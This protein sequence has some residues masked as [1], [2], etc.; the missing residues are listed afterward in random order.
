MK[1]VTPAP[2]IA[3]EKATSSL[4]T[5]GGLRKL[6]GT[7]CKLG[8]GSREPAS[9]QVLSV[10]TVGSS[11]EVESCI[12]DDT[13]DYCPSVRGGD[14]KLAECTRELKASLR[15]QPDNSSRHD[16]KKVSALYDDAKSLEEAHV[17]SSS[18]PEPTF[19]IAL[20]PSRLHG[21]P[22]KS[23]KK[24]R[25]AMQVY[26]NVYLQEPSLNV[27]ETDVAIR[28]KSPYSTPPSNIS[29]TCD[30]KETNREPS[31]LYVEPNEIRPLQMA[32]FKK[33][34]EDE[35]KKLTMPKWQKDLLPQTDKKQKP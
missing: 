19:K 2:E 11:E 5:T 3:A 29:L 27:I 32:I 15:C 4:A 13:G 17:A 28:D 35:K 21:T 12:Y 6:F 23:G 16:F 22:K 20:M 10:V 1:S 9:D 7:K 8:S 33:E 25:C 14:S 24:E 18:S 26:E 30:C 31:G 34:L